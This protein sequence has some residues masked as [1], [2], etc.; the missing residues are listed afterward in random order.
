MGSFLLL[1][2]RLLPSLSTRRFRFT[3]SS[4]LCSIVAP[5]NSKGHKERDELI[6]SS[7]QFGLP[8]GYAIVR[9]PVKGFLLPSTI[10]LYP[11]L[12]FGDFEVRYS[13]MMAMRWKEEKGGVYQIISVLRGE[14]P[15]NPSPMALQ[16]FHECVTFVSASGHALLVCWTAFDGSDKEMK[17]KS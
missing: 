17:K 4:F 14:S 1:F 7:F 10:F 2:A 9:G 11:R 12:A 3:S 15:M 6:P 16:P 13:F 8:L 5:Y